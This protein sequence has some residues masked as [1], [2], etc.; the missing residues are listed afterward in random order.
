MGLSSVRLRQRVHPNVRL[1][2]RLN[3]KEV[4]HKPR[5]FVGEAPAHRHIAVVQIQRVNLKTIGDLAL[6]QP[7]EP[8]EK[9]TALG[10]NVV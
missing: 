5:V 6:V 8:V 4:E 10:R 9:G 7:I 3:L 2:D 1:R